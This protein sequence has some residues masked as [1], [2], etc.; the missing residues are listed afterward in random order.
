MI[1]FLIGGAVR[2]SDRSGR[3]SGFPARISWLDVG[4][5]MPLEQFGGHIDIRQRLRVIEFHAQRV[6]P[7]KQ[8]FFQ[9]IGIL[10]ILF[11]QQLVQNLAG[12]LIRIGQYDILHPD[13]LHLAERI[14]LILPV[15]LFRRSRRCSQHENA[16]RQ[17]HHNPL[18]HLTSS[19]S[20]APFPQSRQAFP[21]SFRTKSIEK[22]P[23]VS[24]MRQTGPVTAWRSADTAGARSGL[25][26][27]NR[28]CSPTSLP[29]KISSASFLRRHDSILLPSPWQAHPR[30]GRRKETT[31]PELAQIP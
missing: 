6:L 31:E 26:W 5:I 8:L 18:F 28:P 14:V 1:F 30:D 19:S 2:S 27:R 17:Q 23:S 22:H 7:R 10:P 21:R 25:P 12:K 20:N 4:V 9:P 16:E 11:R 15:I 3:A 24:A 29:S 13:A